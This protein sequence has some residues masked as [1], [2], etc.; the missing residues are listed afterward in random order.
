MLKDKFATWFTIKRDCVGGWGNFAQV[1]TLKALQC[2]T[3]RVDDEQALVIADDD[4]EF[5]E[6]DK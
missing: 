1:G 6:D 2:W 5:D 3:Q 4:G